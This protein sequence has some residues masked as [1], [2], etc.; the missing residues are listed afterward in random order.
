MSTTQDVDATIQFRMNSTIKDGAFA[1]LR[2]MGI[3]QS[4]TI[5]TSIR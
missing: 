5:Y 4:D 3:S 2:E 1:V